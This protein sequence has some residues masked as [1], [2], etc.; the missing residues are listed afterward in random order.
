M[1]LVK[2]LS[3]HLLVFLGMLLALS[4]LAG[5]SRHVD[6]EGHLLLQPVDDPLVL[7]YRFVPSSKLFAVKSNYLIP[8]YFTGDGLANA[9]LIENSWRLPDTETAVIFYKDVATTRSVEQYNI[10]TF[11]VFSY[12]VHDFNRDGAD[13]I[14]LTYLFRDSLWLELITSRGERLYK[15]FLVTGED[16]DH[17]GYWDGNGILCTVHDFNGD[18]Y[19]EIIVGVDTGYDLYP[20]RLFCLDWRND[21]R[22][23]EYD[24]S[25]VICPVYTFVVEPSENEPPMVM[26]AV[27]SKG[28]AAVTGDMTDAHAYLIVLDENGRERWK[29]ETGDAFANSQVAII[30]Y[31]DDGV[32][33]ILSSYHYTDPEVEGK[34][35]SA[36]GGRLEVYNLQGEKLH[37]LDLGVGWIIR[38]F[39]RFDFNGDSFDEVGVSCTDNC[40]YVFGEKLKFLKKYKSYSGLQDIE[41]RDFLGDGTRQF[42]V[43]TDNKLWLLNNDFE[44]LAQFGSDDI[45]NLKISA[46]FKPDDSRPVYSIIL[47]DR[48]QSFNYVMALKRSPWYTI[49]SRNPILAFLA[50]FVP[51][52]IIILVIWFIM[53]KFRQKN[54]VIKKQRDRLDA[55]LA[56]LK[57]AQEKLIAAEKYKQARDIA[58]GFAHEIRNALFP[59]RSSLKQLRKLSRTSRLDNEQVEKYAKNTDRA[60][61]RAVDITKL[62]SQYT[63]LDS[64][65][66]P[67]AVNLSRLVNELIQAYE[68]SLRENGIK[69]ELSGATETMRVSANY[70]QLYLVLNNLI[71][72][73]FDSLT[74]RANRV[75][76]IMIKEDKDFVTLSFQDSG[77]G[78]SRE[79]IHRVFDTFYSTKPDKG[80][81]L[82]LALVKKIVEMYGGSISVSSE[83]DKGTRFDLKLK[84]FKNSQ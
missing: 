19:E 79:N 55:A 29:I 4:V 78:I 65:Y 51:L 5:C 32:P 6:D 3:K 60:V 63:R 46:V 71:L 82:G 35:E 38:S 2:D 77:C 52:S 64:N 48:A 1:T 44:P 68:V 16:R 61:A 83:L 84:Q 17:N 18:G 37:E 22:L 28:N 20:R 15:T 76:F 56:E 66:L 12:L 81:G 57:D 33:D 58:G 54:I 43:T 9:C 11:G 70:Q 31:D 42:I 13:E 62:I 69:L 24:V 26:V 39:Q 73:S 80:T 36:E 74:N 50:A 40:F 7:P 23:W 72:N 59:A 47:T 75:I 14:A 53:A 67:E 45:A 25:G 30:N 34:P 41:C 8:M 21:R 27:Q 10:P 49:F